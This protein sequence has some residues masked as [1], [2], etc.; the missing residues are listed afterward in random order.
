MKNQ[1]LL[2]TVFLGFSSVLF[3]QENRSNRGWNDANQTTYYMGEKANENNEFRATHY[4]KSPTN[5]P[6]S[7]GWNDLREHRTKAIWADNSTIVSDEKTGMHTFIPY[8]YVGE[9]DILWAKRVKKVID[10]RVPQNHPIYFP[11]Q[12]NYDRYYEDGGGILLNEVLSGTDA[13][14]NLFQILKDAATTLTP[15]GDPLVSVYNSSLTRKFSTREII[16]DRNNAE[17]G[18]FQR[19][20]TQRFFDDFGEEIDQIDIVIE[21]APLD[22][23]GYYIEEE[24]FF[25][26]R[27]AKL[28]YRYVSITPLVRG[29]GAAGLYTQDGLSVKPLGTFYFPEIR[30]LLA[31]H[32]VYPLDDNIAQRMSF[33]E[34]FHRKLFASNIIKE[35]NVYDRNISDYLPGR[36]LD[37]LLEGE[38]IKEQ[39]R[40]Y[41]TDMWN[42]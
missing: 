8:T 28:D 37:Q 14:K 38:R 33:D 25:D 42:Y 4:P 27:R 9:D 40:L 17:P 24:I 26:K 12:V 41:E 35:T 15:S 21:Y 5:N 39:I 23:V 2:F 22:I 7:N 16:G 34:Y 32:K 30:Q 19:R 11:V 6:D 20:G 3:S 36:T 1:V 31:N 13:R 18:V 10:V 29:D